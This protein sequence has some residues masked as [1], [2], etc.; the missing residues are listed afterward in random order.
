MFE[1]LELAGIEFDRMEGEEGIEGGHSGD[2]LS[3]H[4]FEDEQGEGGSRYL[5]SSASSETPH[6][7]VSF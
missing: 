4:Y 3:N 5:Q 6:C 7:E 1:E 2:A